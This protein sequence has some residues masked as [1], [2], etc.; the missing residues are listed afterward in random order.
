MRLKCSREE[1][2]HMLKFTVVL[3]TLML[4]AVI[5]SGCDIGAFVEFEGEEEEEELRGQLPEWEVLDLVEAYYNSI[6]AENIPDDMTRTEL[7]KSTLHPD[8]DIEVTRT[9]EQENFYGENLDS[10]YSLSREEYVK[11]YEDYFYTDI[12]EID[13]PESVKY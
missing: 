5:F 2:Q 6:L 3:F 11:G 7:M 8:Q 1:K 10:N 12:S 4:A 9:F 13:I